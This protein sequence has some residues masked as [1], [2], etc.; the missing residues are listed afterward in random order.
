[1]PQRIRVA[2]GFSRQ[3]PPLEISRVETIVLPVTGAILMLIA[4][5]SIIFNVTGIITVGLFVLA[6]ILPVIAYIRI[7]RAFYKRDQG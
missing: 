4:T 2:L 5:V 1:M 7:N 6:A 3:W